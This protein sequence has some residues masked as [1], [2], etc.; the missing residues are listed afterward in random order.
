M[1]K[2]AVINLL[3]LLIGAACSGQLLASETETLP[4]VVATVLGEEIRGND[5]GEM[6]EVILTRLFDAYAMEKG[7]VVSDEEVDLY[8]KKLRQG[9]AAEGLNAEDDLSAEEAAEV[10][11]MREQMGRAL[12]RQ[13]KINKS[14]YAAYGG[15]IIYQQLG[16]EPLDAY[17]Q[18]LDKNQAAGD[19]TIDDPEMA[20][21]FWQYF[22]DDELHDFMAP[23]S[24]DEA[25][26]FTIPPWERKS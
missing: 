10:E 17:R 16:P 7:I 20:E 24:D 2:R 23:G 6:Q 1:R 4:P 22:T 9:M 5:A 11:A 25:K 19:F 18:F 12:I 8:V 26:A 21:S 15:R 13:W 3:T 14:L